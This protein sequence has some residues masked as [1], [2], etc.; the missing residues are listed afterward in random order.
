MASSTDIVILLLGLSTR[1]TDFAWFGG[2]F[3]VFFWFGLVCL[4]GWGF[5]SLFC[6]GCV[7][8]SLVLGLVFFLFVFFFCG[9]GILVFF[10]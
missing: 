8:G 10:L 2:F 6:L 4:L 5:F 3:W 7:F 9:G 1:N